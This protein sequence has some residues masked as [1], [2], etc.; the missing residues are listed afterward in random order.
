MKPPLNRLSAVQLV[1]MMSA[2]DVTCEAVTHSFVDAIKQRESEV[3]AFT[4]ID[5]G[6]ALDIARAL[7]SGP[8]QG[9]LAGLPLAVKDVIDTAG[10]RTEHGSPIFAGRVASVD[11]ACV[12]AARAAGAFVLGKTATAELA[13]F[14]P[15][16][17]R[18]PHA[19]AHTPGGSSSGS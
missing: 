12:A 17:T 13:N 18:N 2:R 9:P 19:P 4:W 16:A 1:Q 11:A 3:Q 8:L 6:R 10:I 5:T 7:D 15:G 14:T